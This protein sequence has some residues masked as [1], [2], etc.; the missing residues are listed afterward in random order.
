M[1]TLIPKKWS[2]SMIINLGSIKACT[3]F[4]SCSLIL[5]SC[6]E[7]PPA[8]ETAKLVKAMQLG[9]SQG[10]SERSFPGRAE[11]AQEAT[12]SFRVGG[13]VEELQ[14]NVGDTVEKGEVLAIL[15][16]TDFNNAL[17]VADGALAKALAA[18][19][20][21]QANHDRSISVQQDDAG[22]ISQRAIDRT[23]AALS[24]ATAAADAAKSARSIAADRLAHTKLKAPFAGE[25]VA[26]YVEAFESVI[27]K[28][29]VV[30]LLDRTN[31]EFKVAVPESLIGYANDVEAAKVVFDANKEVEV[32]ATVKEIGR[33][34]SRGTRTFPV[35]L[36]LEQTQ[37]FD[38]L[39]GM[40]GTA[41][42]T[43]RLADSDRHLNIPAAA[44]F[45][46]P[47]GGSAVWI[48][49]NG[50]LVKQA[51]EVGLPGDFGIEVLSGLN[52]GDWIVTA[53]VSSLTEG[54]LVKVI[55]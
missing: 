54:Q 33:E 48:I 34:A 25:V 39:P 6:S 47:K 1:K 27:M 49:I 40:A 11:A 51:V 9:D 2:A 30:R 14:V 3:L 15:D 23:K 20:N 22:A 12:L 37:A 41:F 31:V 13:Q 10:V 26:N 28:Q 44:L 32:P 42:V 53:G 29:P 38:I 8:P 7:P 50:G 17:N 43:A 21:A 35:T 36:L 52:S 24:I 18:L 5:V 16:K 45:Q 46:H 4:L 55:Q 19:E